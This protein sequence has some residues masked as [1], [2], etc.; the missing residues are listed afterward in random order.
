MIPYAENITDKLKDRHSDTRLL[1]IRLYVSTELS[2]AFDV[3]C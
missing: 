2:A 1:L 3:K